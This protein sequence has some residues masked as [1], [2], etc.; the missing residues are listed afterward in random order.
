[1]DPDLG[2]F[3]ERRLHPVRVSVSLM[4]QQLELAKGSKD[5][6]VDADLFESLISTIEIF[7]EDYDA[8]YRSAGGPTTV[9]ER[10]FVEAA[11][12]TIKI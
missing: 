3:V 11:K 4:N 8:R 12:A 6:V 7:L 10:K 1:M 9:S 2:K 5:V